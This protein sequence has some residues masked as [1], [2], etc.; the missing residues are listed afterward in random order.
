MKI[1]KK[2]LCVISLA[3]VFMSGFKS[4]SDRI[5]NLEIAEFETRFEKV[6]EG[7]K[8]EQVKDILGDTSY[9]SDGQ[10]WLSLEESSIWGY[11]K[12]SHTRR[13]APVVYFN[14]R[15][16]K[17]AHTKLH[18]ERMYIDHPACWNIIYWITC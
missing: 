12:Y 8:K 18:E 7:M 15:T 10:W 4:I 5:K 6:K 14:S 1:S 3:L 13:Y 17:V 11:T 2:N 9:R 16:D